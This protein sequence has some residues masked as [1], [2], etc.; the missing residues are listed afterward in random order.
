MVAATGR[1]L[2]HTAS[3]TSPNHLRAGDLLV[4]NASATLPAALPA[5]RAD[6]SAVDLHL[7]T[8][9]PRTPRPL[10]R[11]GAR[12][13]AAA[14]RRTG[15]DARAPARRPPRT[16]LAPY[17][18]PG[19]LW[20]AQLDLPS[21]CSTTCTT[22]APRS[23]TPTSRTRARSR[24]TRR[25]SPPSPAARRCR[26]PAA[27]SPG[28]R[29]R[30]LRER[31]ISVQRI[32]LHTGVSS[33]G[34]RRA[35][36]PGALQVTR[37]H[38]R[39]AS[40]D[41]RRG[42]GDR[43]RHDRRA[44][45]RDRRR[46][47]T[48]SST[49]ASGWTNLDRS[50][51]SAASAAV[52]GLLTG[53]HEPERQPPADARGDRRPR[54]ARTLLR[55]RARARL[56]LARVRRPA[57]DCCA[58]HLDSARCGASRSASGSP[59]KGP[60]PASGSGTSPPTRSSGP[61]T[62]ARSTASRAARSPAGV[63]GLPRPHRPSR[64]PRGDAPARRRPR[65]S[66]ARRTSSTCASRCPTSGERWLHARARA[67]RG[68]T[69]ARSA[70]PAC[71]A[72]SPSAATA[73]R[74]TRSS[75]PPAR[76][77]P[78]SMDPVETLEEV[79]QLA[80]PR[81][82]RLVRGPAR[83]DDGAQ[84]VAVAHVDP[85][86]VRWA[87]ELQDR[88]PPDPDSPTGAPAVI[89]TG[90][91]EL[92]PVID[93]AL[94]EAAAL[95]EEQIAARARA[96]DALGD[97]RPADRPRPHARGDDLR[98]GGV[99]AASTRRASSSWPRSS[100][101]APGSRST[102]RGCSRA[103]TATAETLQ[104]ALLPGHAAGAARLRARRPLRAQRRARPRRRRLVRRVPAARR[105]LRDRD[106]RR[107]RARD[108]ARRRRWARSATRCAPTRSRAPGPGEVIDD[109]HALVDASRGR[110]HVRHRRL[111]RARPAHRRGRARAAPAT[112]RR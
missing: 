64:G 43:R 17:L 67:V 51:P 25:S 24:T 10:G 60:R 7:S 102:T 77:W 87:R 50:R 110:D 109:L 57:P 19:R 49:P 86:K 35:P 103:S 85:E 76:C 62:W 37:A 90:R 31:G 23:A 33:P 84:Q 69:A 20:I 79:A 2:V 36:V 111:R 16:L 65:S 73:R 112:C 92:Y 56:P 98:V 80:V 26:A 70:S 95:D 34:A 45:A 3:S 81:A 104:R 101:A 68:P 6:G 27:R 41:A 61:T 96:A 105:P 44:R 82:R 59:W 78:R 46:R 63:A 14:R 4:V 107:R 15:R 58:D 21:R 13:T 75:T 39:R 100:A 99:R 47:T 30:A 29:S 52:D 88:Y 38:G 93:S 40:T 89:R 1:P 55:R 8:P 22:T 74:R 83:A 71:S 72:T 106:R 108:G 48:A 42:R 66:T 97:G 12:A 91:S 18:S 9:D 11:R 28:A 54:A 32:T 94:L 53:W 5:R